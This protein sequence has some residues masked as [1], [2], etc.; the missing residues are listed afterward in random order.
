MVTQRRLC[1]VPVESMS[2]ICGDFVLK[3]MEI[4][5]DSDSEAAADMSVM[6]EITSKTVLSERKEVDT[7]TQI[8]EPLSTDNSD[9]CL[10]VFSSSNE[11]SSLCV[12]TYGTSTTCSAPENINNDSCIMP[13]VESLK[14][15]TTSEIE[16][17]TAS[18]SISTATTSTCV[19]A[20]GTT[21]ASSVPVL[22]TTSTM[23]AA[24]SVPVKTNSD[25]ASQVKATSQTG[26]SVVREAPSCRIEN[27]PKHPQSAS[28]IT[29][30]SPT[31]VEVKHRPETS[32][33][34]SEN[35]EASAKTVHV[36]NSVGTMASVAPHIH[37]SS[38][39]E[40]PRLTTDMSALSEHKKLETTDA[41]PKEFPQKIGASQVIIVTCNG[42]RQVYCRLCSVR[43]Q[44]S[45]HLMDIK[46]QQK[47]VVCS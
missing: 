43:M 44:N 34:A 23:S 9:T 42:K 22:M 47:Y 18:I 31:S 27:H 38:P 7:V 26:P 4:D 28:K 13:T 40:A 5:E 29:A 15:S 21:S 6:T 46:H 45:Q 41:K 3:D 8:Q 17:P 24:V 35:T 12:P 11:K 39:P 16:E 10:T 36:R 1:C 2:S 19:A 14:M 32:V 30:P 37:K 20:S 33:G 25:L